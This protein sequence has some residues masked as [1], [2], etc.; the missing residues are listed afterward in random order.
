MW[1][2]DPNSPTSPSAPEEVDWNA[3]SNSRSV[4]IFATSCVWRGKHSPASTWR[5]R[6]KKGGWVR[7]LSGVI[8]LRFQIEC[9]ERFEG[10]IQSQFLADFLASHGQ[11][12]GSGN[13]LRMNDGS[14]PTSSESFARWSRTSSSWR[15]SEDLFGEGSKLSLDRWPAWGSM[16]SGVATERP[17][18][19][20][21]TAGRGSSWSRGEY[22]TP[23]A[24]DYGT[25]QNEGKVPHDRQTPG[26]DSFRSRS[27]DRHGEAGLD[28]Q[29]KAW[30]TPQ[31]TDGA[32]AARHTTETGAMHPGTSMTDAV[33]RFPPV[34]T[35]TGPESRDTSGLPSPTK[36][37]L[38]WMFV[39]W[40]MGWIDTGL[41]SFA[42]SATES[43]PSRQ[44]QRSET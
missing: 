16:R 26:T 43:S 21:P 25:S 5:R 8:S 4:S 42:S 6:W 3:E 19:E 22:P 7:L 30:P 24:T 9:S 13:V 36:R 17:R 28:R 10:W 35:E 15:T 23:S 33:R 20:H 41:I 11:P 2:Y 27:G 44:P 14:G 38:N 18:P 39:A 12:Q 34:P 31:T 40:L 37:K 32:S 29:S 1:L